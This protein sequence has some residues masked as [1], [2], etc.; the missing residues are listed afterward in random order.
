LRDAPP[1]VFG[2]GRACLASSAEDRWRTISQSILLAADEVVL[3][4]G[5]VILLPLVALAACLGSFGLASAADAQQ[6]VAPRRIGVLLVGLSPE[7]KEVQQF[8]QGLRDG[9][10]S[11][12]RNVVIE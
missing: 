12:G 2:L 7:S 4:N 5:R 9:G 6:P 1:L 3:V 10:Y 8:R 11:E